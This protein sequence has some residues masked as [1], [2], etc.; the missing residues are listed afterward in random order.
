MSIDIASHLGQWT[1]HF[2]NKSTIGKMLSSPVWLSIIIVCTMLL[3]LYLIGWTGSPTFKLIFYMLATSFTLIIIH[4]G[5]FK[6]QITESNE[7][8]SATDIVQD[9]TMSERMS[10]IDNVKPRDATTAAQ[11]FMATTVERQPVDNAD[12][13]LGLVAHD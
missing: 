13:L 11:S 9:I 5:V 4:D 7:T 8:D 1:D 3:I 6:A 12:D 10:N 2:A